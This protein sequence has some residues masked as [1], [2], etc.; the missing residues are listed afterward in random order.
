[1]S[2]IRA[3][4]AG[5]GQDSEKLF[6]AP[7]QHYE[8]GNKVSIGSTLSSA[9]AK[10]RG[11]NFE[12]GILV[13]PQGFVV[14][15]YKGGAHSVSFGNEPPSKFKGATITHNHPGNIPVFSVADIA[16]PA[17]YAGLGGKPTGMRATT[18]SNG[19]FSIVA[20]RQDADWNK[21]ATAYN[22]AS[23]G[24]RKAALTAGATSP[25]DFAGHYEK[26]FQANAPKYGFSFTW[27]R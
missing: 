16:A 12:T 26:W 27:E 21:L 22:K 1:M 3:M 24:L 20:K 18:K 17:M 15:A 8:G 7:W 23:S 25:A 13:D 10:I 5:N 4:A 2:A 14:A 11:N 6:N 19:T 9:E